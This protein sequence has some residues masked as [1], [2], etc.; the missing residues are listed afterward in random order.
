MVSLQFILLMNKIWNSFSMKALGSWGTQGCSL[1][2]G[3]E[4]LIWV[5]M[6]GIPLALWNLRVF[7][8]VGNILGD[9]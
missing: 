4:V 2:G 1:K 7:E 5:R 8:K 6:Y 3:M 9:F